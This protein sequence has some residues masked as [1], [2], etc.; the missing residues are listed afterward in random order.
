MTSCPSTWNDKAFEKLCQNRNKSD[1]I[2][3]V[4]VT[5]NS[6]GFSYSNV[7]CAICNGV[8]N[9]SYWYVKIHFLNGYQKWVAKRDKV[10]TTRLMEQN[11]WSAVIP[12]HYSKEFCIRNPSITT[13]YNQLLS[14]CFVYAMPVINDSNTEL[15]R[16][17]HCKQSS[18]DFDY[19]KS[20]DLVECNPN[21]GSHGGPTSSAGRPGSVGPVGTDPPPDPL[22]ISFTFL[23]PF[24][25]YPMQPIPTRKDQLPSSEGATN[26]S[27]F[28]WMHYNSSEYVMYQ[29]KTVLVLSVRKMIKQG[30]YSKLN[31]TVYVCN[32]NTSSNRN[33]MDISTL[34][35]YVCSTISLISLLFFLITNL[36]FRELR[37]LH[38]KNLMSLSC[39]LI[40]F[41][42]V[43]FALYQTKIT[44]VCDVI[45]G[46]LHYALLAMFTWMSVVGY[47]VSKKFA[48]K[49][50]ILI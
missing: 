26:T 28:Q 29:N 35:T 14:F 32:N 18:F 1:P 6:T 5:E 44:W 45:T 41:H 3:F 21:Q 13:T 49:G 12:S 2:S 47:D 4:P 50:K 39:A 31:H 17:P 24:S 27:C 43:F 30:D 15:R 34:I 9:F 48:S 33:K 40:I 10:P 23:F 46:L 11:A 38:F 8:K 42:S 37:S 20:Y 7:Y 22:L 36:L 19:C 25:K 16:N